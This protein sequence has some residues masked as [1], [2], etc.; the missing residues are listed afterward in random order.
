MTR[1]QFH[2]RF[3]HTFFIQ[4]SFLC[5]EFGFEQTFVRKICTKNV[6]EIDQQHNKVVTIFKVLNEQIDSSVSQIK[7]WLEITYATLLKL[8]SFKSKLRIFFRGETNIPRYRTRWFPHRRQP[9][10]GSREVGASGRLSPW[11]SPKN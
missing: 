6:D 1:C 10:Q 3:T 7:H 2:Q 8:V 9:I 4:T 11:L 5:L